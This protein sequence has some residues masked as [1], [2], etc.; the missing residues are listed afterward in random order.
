MMRRVFHPEFQ[1]VVRQ[2]PV[3]RNSLALWTLAQNGF[4]LKGP[5]GTLVAVYT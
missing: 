4:L 1:N 5:E 2:Y 3:P